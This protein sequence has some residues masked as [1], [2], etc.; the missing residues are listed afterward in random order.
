MKQL[1]VLLFCMTSL[2]LFSCKDNHEKEA[3]IL[4][5]WQ[6]TK[7]EATDTKQKYPTDKVAFHFLPE[8]KYTATLG[9]RNEKGTWRIEGSLLYTHADDFAEIA[10]QINKLDAS[11]LELQMNR[12]GIQEIMYLQK[13]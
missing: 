7:W 12:G 6:A 4:G 8:H 10:T 13:K 2:A 5:D 3:L 11:Q 1:F 9:D